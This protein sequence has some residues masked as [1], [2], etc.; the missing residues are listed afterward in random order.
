[1]T[2]REQIRSYLVLLE[3]LNWDPTLLQYNKQNPEEVTSTQKAAL[4]RLTDQAREQGHTFDWAIARLP[5][6]R[7]ITGFPRTLTKWRLSIVD[8][9]ESEELMEVIKQQGGHRRK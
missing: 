5:D 6:G 4:D 3:T 2:P 1:M 7:F 8:Q 9:G